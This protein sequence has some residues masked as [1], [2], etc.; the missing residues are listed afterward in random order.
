MLIFCTLKRLV[1]V[2][3]DSNVLFKIIVKSMILS[4][5]YQIQQINFNAILFEVLNLHIHHK[6]YCHCGYY[7]MVQH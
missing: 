6:L 3:N 1:V 5:L 4:Q 2:E 7:V